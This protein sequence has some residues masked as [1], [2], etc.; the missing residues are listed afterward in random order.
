MLAALSVAVFQYWGKSQYLATAATAAPDNGWTQTPWGPLGPA[1]RDLLIK[2][3]QAG[4]WEAPAGQ[5]AE[6]RA[7]GARVREVGRLIATEHTDLDARVRDVSA[8]LGVALP[9]Q[10]SDQQKGWVTEIISQPKPDFDRTFVQRLRAAHGKVLPTIAQVRAGT[11]NDLVRSFATTS[12]EFV[13]R[14]HEYLES[15]KLVDY[16]A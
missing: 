15:T 16:S 1:D 5:Q 11:R 14:H 3:R 13:T 4:L 7:S 10:P 8:R 6:Q 9:N 2:V 12:A